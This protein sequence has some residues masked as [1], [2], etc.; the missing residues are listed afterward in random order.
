MLAPFAGAFVGIDF[1]D[2]DGHLRFLSP[3][4]QI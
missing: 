4:R 1:D 3:I 2:S